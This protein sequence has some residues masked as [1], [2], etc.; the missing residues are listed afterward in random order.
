MLRY[1]R[2][3]VLVTNPTSASVAS[4]GPFIVPLPGLVV[5]EFMRRLRDRLDQ[6][7]G[8]Y[9]FNWFKLNLGHGIHTIE[10]KAELIATASA[11]AP[12]GGP[13]SA[14]TQVIIGKRTL[15]AMPLKVANDETL[16]GPDR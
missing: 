6:T 4:A 8:A 13:D 10:V 5:T 15:S 7:S 1:L 9:T 14:S 12:G 3:A 2:V 11:L 16:T